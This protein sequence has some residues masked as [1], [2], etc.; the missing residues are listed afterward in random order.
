MIIVSDTSIIS[1]LIVLRRLDLLRQV[2]G[3]VIIPKAVKQEI[4]KLERFGYEL[5]GFQDADWI[6][7]RSTSLTHL[8]A[9]LLQNLDEGESHAI[10]LAREVN[11]DYLAID[12]KAGRAVAQQYGFKTIGL[13][14]ILIRAKDLGF[15]EHVK[16][17]IDDLIHKAGFYLS[18]KLYQ[19]VLEDQG[20]CQ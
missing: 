14:G 17:L 15:I 11:A 1:N 6:S 20:E 16:P 3:Q 18:P 2:F 10:A 13:I 9:Q 7:T 8:V 19:R 5:D 12:E 4:L